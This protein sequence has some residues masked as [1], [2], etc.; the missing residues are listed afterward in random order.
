TLENAFELWQIGAEISFAPTSFEYLY[1][2]QSAEILLGSKRIG[3]LGRIHP[4]IAQKYQISEEVFV[5]Q[6]SLS[7]IFDYLINY[8][9][10]IKEI[11]EIAG[12]DLQEIKVFDVY[13]NAELRNNEKKS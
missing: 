5:A 7:Q 8:N 4:Q 10:V 12:R 2:P 11:K 13:Q 6:I 1:S 3:F 9:E